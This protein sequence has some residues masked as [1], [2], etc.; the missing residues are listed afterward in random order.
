MY[1]FTVA[2]I[3]RRMA[4]TDPSLRSMGQDRPEE[5]KEEFC[6]EDEMGA[7]WDFGPV[8]TADK[9]NDTF[10]SSVCEE[11]EV[12]QPKK[13][14]LSMVMSQLGSA[15]IV[16]VPS[17]PIPENRSII[18]AVIPELVMIDKQIVG[19][20]LMCAEPQQ[21]MPKTYLANIQ[22]N[23]P[24]AIIHGNG[25]TTNTISACREWLAG[26]EVSQVTAITVAGV[27]KSVLVNSMKCRRVSSEFPARY[28]RRGPDDESALYVILEGC[29][30]RG[31]RTCK[32]PWL[33][34][35]RENLS[36][37]SDAQG[38]ELVVNGLVHRVPVTRTVVLDYD[39][40]Y[41]ETHDKY[42]V[43]G[44]RGLTSMKPGR[45]LCIQRDAF[46]E[47]LMMYEGDRPTTT[48]HYMLEIARSVIVEDLVKL[49]PFISA[50]GF[51]DP[52]MVRRSVTT[53]IDHRVAHMAQ[54]NIGPFMWTV[55]Q[56]GTNISTMTYSAQYARHIYEV[57]G[58]VSPSLITET[59]WCHQVCCVGHL[60]ART[61]MAIIQDSRVWRTMDHRLNKPC[62]VS[63]VPLTTTYRVISCSVRN[64][65]LSNIIQKWSIH[66]SARRVI[67]Y[68]SRV[69][70]CPEISLPSKIALSGLS[71]DMKYLDSKM[72]K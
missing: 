43:E 48:K 49:L 47:V 60:M 68:M 11:V 4:I 10:S 45:A 53:A 12:V 70:D 63:L 40:R 17:H 9:W 32:H 44:V 38:V 29:A 46:V 15:N 18:M 21:L 5:E 59:S 52:V 37:L 71:I 14:S 24:A 2:E 65:T 31:L 34:V 6:F 7:E 19:T 26:A 61:S 58:L 25:V 67:I 42:R 30:A 33:P 16:V 64:R 54:A 1:E 55:G 8:G 28:V 39:G 22:I 13:E 20:W 41:Y 36:N 72:K 51:V 69:V 3:I 23:G 62:M 57:L 35:T 56:G 50:S 66:V 27:R